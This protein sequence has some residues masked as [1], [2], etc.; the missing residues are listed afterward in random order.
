MG[1][2]SDHGENQHERAQGPKQ[3]TFFTR[4]GT[5]RACM[6]MFVCVHDVGA[7]PMVPEVKLDIPN[8][9]LHFSL[10]PATDEFV[11][12]VLACP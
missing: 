4:C 1:E 10:W 9:L 8:G 6:G 11:F 5:Q 7:L 3:P 12:R 2:V